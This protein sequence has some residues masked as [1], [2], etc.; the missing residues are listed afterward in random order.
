MRTI[1]TSYIPK[2]GEA[3]RPQYW[4]AT[5][6]S[7]YFSPSSHRI[8]SI[9]TAL[10]RWVAHINAL[11][12]PASLIEFIPVSVQEVPEDYNRTIY[13]GYNAGGRI[14]APLIV[15]GKTLPDLTAKPQWYSHKNAW[16]IWFR[17]SDHRQPL[18][19]GQEE[20]LK[21]WFSPQ[22][23]KANTNELLI[24]LKSRLFA[25]TKKTVAEFV[26]GQRAYCDKIESSAAKVLG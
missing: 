15:R 16:E 24:T 25:R 5:L 17:S 21:E 18:T 22:L 14:N 11:E 9:N 20:Q 1:Q 19:P 12:L 2:K 26:E 7:E 6:G 23:L 3:E 8:E 10:G 13:C 4:H